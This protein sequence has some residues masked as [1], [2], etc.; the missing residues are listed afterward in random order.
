M[1]EMGRLPIRIE[2]KGIA[3]LQIGRPS[4]VRLIE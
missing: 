3:G 4:V 1:S 2:I